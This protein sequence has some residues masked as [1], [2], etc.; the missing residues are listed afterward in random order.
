MEPELTVIMCALNEMGRI[1]P[2]LEPVR[3]PVVP[4]GPDPTTAC[5]GGSALGAKGA[6]SIHDAGGRQGGR[7]HAATLSPI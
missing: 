6:L 7:G 1:Q 2:A 4:P 5:G 3:G